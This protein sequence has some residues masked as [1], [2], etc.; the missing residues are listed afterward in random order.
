MIEMQKITDSPINRGKRV[1]N[2]IYIVKIT[3]GLL[4]CFM[5]G[6]VFVWG[7]IAYGDF[8]TI[9]FVVI[10]VIITSFFENIWNATC[11]LLNIYVR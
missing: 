7:R 11:V 2:L 5:A 1:V 10:F 6:A 4:L 9:K 8:G 3:I